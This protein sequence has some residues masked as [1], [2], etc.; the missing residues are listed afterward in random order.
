M[1][2]H[3]KYIGQLSSVS[4]GRDGVSA[5]GAGPKIPRDTAVPVSKEVHDHYAKT[6][7]W[8][9]CDAEGAVPEPPPEKEEAKPKRSRKP[10]E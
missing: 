7:E 3:I 1:A 5:L 9:S 10:K 2:H 8:V 4:L 6:T